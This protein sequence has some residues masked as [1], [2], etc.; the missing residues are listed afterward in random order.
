[1]A[2]DK[3]DDTNQNVAPSTQKGKEPL[4]NSES[5]SKR[6]SFDS[7]SEMRAK[8]A[9]MMQNMALLEQA[10]LLKGNRK[11][12]MEEHRFWNTQPVP[13]HDEEVKD[14]GCIEPSVPVDQ[15]SKEA[16]KLP[17]E[18][19][20][21]ELDLNDEKEVKELYELLT[22]NYVEDDDA[23]FRFDYSARFLKW[24][25]QPP[26]WKKSWHVGVRV[27]ANKKL[28]A[29]ISGIPADL[30]TYHVTQPLTE[31]NFLC[32]H[33]K[34]RSKRLAPVL[35]REITRRSHLENIFQAVYTAGVV[36]PKP[37]ATCRYFHR[38]LN[39]KKLV[40]CNFSH[41]P[42]KWTLA[43]MIKH[44]KVP[45]E[46]STKGLR[47]MREEDAE[48]VRVLL[49]NYL[50]R[51]D[52]SV[53]FETVE[54]VKH[55]IVP[56]EDV[57]WSYVVE[58]TETGK[59]TDMFSFYS[60]PS[61]VINNPKHSTLNAAYMFYYAIDIPENHKASKEDEEK[62]IKDRLNEL[63]KDALV[64]AR[65]AGFDV[66]NALKLM[67]NECFVTEQ[68]FGPG[69]GYLNYYLY[70]WRCPDVED[71]NGFP[72]ALTF[73]PSSF[74]FSMF[75]KMS[76]TLVQSKSIAAASLLVP[77]PKRW[78]LY[79]WPFAS[80]FYPVFLYVYFFQYDVYLGSEEWTFVSLGS[81]LTLHALTF[82]SCQ[83]SVSIKALFTCIKESDV[84][85]ATVI[86]LVPF[87]YQGTGA[88]VEIHHGKPTASNPEGEISFIFQ[89]KK[90]IWDSN[91]KQFRELVYPSDL[92]PPVATYQTT[93]GLTTEKEINEVSEKYGL[94]R[95]EIP[96]PTF[97]ELF[98][99][100]AV[101]PF[102]VFQIF[103]V[104][105]W[106][107]DEYWY[108]SLF[109]LFMLVV[110]E[111]TVVFQRLKTI[112]EF[113]GMNQKP[114]ELYVK[115]QKKWIQIQSD[116]LLPGDLVSI[117][118]TKDDQCVPCD[119]V[120]AQGSCIV[121]EAMLSGESTP[122]LKESVAL[123]KAEEEFD[124]K[125]ADR[126]HVLYGGTKV[127]QVTGP[128]SDSAPDNGCL[129]V[130]A[131]T[132]F[133]TS[134][135]ELVRT[136]IFSTERVS[137][138]NLEA[139]L[140]ILFLLVF[141]IAASAYVWIE[142]VEKDRKRSK[143]LLD[144]I[145][146]ITSV[147][148]PELPMELSLAVNSSLVALSKFAIFCTEPFR[149]PYAGRV[150]VCCFDKTGTLTGEDLKLEGVAFA[151]PDVPPTTL[152]EATEVPESTKWVLSTAHALVQLED[153]IIGDPMEKETLK[154]LG[155]NLGAHD[156]VTPK[157]SRKESI[158]I[159]R[160]FQ[161]S[162]ALKR[163]SSVSILVHP[164]F[165]QKKTLVAV[166]GAPETLR[167]MY[168]TVPEEYD[169]VY[170]HFTR[171]GSRVLALGY[172][173][174]ED[175]MK[176]EQI[177][178]ISRES[179]ESDLIFAGFIVFTCP[180]KEDAVEA[181][182][183]LNDSSHRCVMITGDNPLTACAVAREVG[184]VERD[185]LIVDKE[186]TSKDNFVVFHNID[187]TFRLEVDPAK[188]VDQQ[189]LD[190]H[191]ICLTGSAMIH[192][193]DNH[194]MK[195]LLEHTWV[196]ARVSPSQKEYLLT[197]YK[198]LGYTTL[199]AGDGTNDVGAL[200]QAHIGVAL[201]DGTPEDLQ[202]IA[203]RQRIE[204]LKNMYEQQKQLAAR[205]NAPLPPPP[206]A[207]AH[208]YP[209]AVQRNQQAEQNLTP[210]QKRQL[211]QKKKLENMTNKLME[212]MDME[213]PPTIKFGDASVAAPFTSKLR[214]V[215]AINNIIRQGRCTLV[216]T[217]QMYK[218]LA[219]NCLISAYSLSVLYLDGIKFGDLQVTISGMLMAVCFLC[220]SR[221]KPLQKLSKERPQPNIFNPYIILSVLGQFAVHIAALVYINAL[222]KH[223]EPPKE[224]D[225]EGEFEPSLLNSGVYLI[226]LAM[227]VSTFAINYQ[228]HPFRERIQ[229][230]KTLY[231][232][233]M[234]V[235]GIALAGATEMFPEVNEQLKLVKFP[236]AFR[237]KLT[238]CMV[239]DFGVSYLIEVVTK[240]LFADN[241]AK[242]IAQRGR[243]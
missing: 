191:D 188:P 39:P 210:A 214:N 201:L 81:I 97:T 186:E 229:D 167:T 73:S 54:D 150:D 110:F 116:E 11:K 136:M 1:M 153:G 155:W 228:G 192:F 95:F 119:L 133:G 124:L 111:G 16:P 143:L 17:K 173:F 212:D 86:K 126:L 31:I 75:A 115:R 43:R 160:R 158:H 10:E 152:V 2:N 157:E 237:D 163:Q 20:W 49:N 15:V 232:G 71:D 171:K 7:Q 29:F 61:T 193:T 5:S 98:K 27:A 147:V 32:V 44:Y 199:M 42:P 38:S 112:G 8:L 135:G 67:D 21:C 58:N 190:K 59:I 78:H 65:N 174:L 99:E 68:K 230:N 187:D 224:V 200:K 189:L 13:Q 236:G 123:R 62:Y 35:I 93:S 148:P 159:R 100:H 239:L 165:A 72:G 146:I 196:Y 223:Y 121:N 156:I 9:A 104:G 145:L 33:K 45:D 151:D 226:Q 109:T 179:V 162:S 3:D 94:N 50:S 25:L 231:Y 238:M 240:K 46:T 225:L 108:Y 227:Q 211:E 127:L 182:K 26:K 51:F 103:C 178:D 34:L 134:Q 52:L 101:A 125:N 92:H 19:E 220:I 144:C 219:L 84:H 131:R 113:R 204:R 185:V 172:K 122:L 130:V 168:I 149:I 77:L 166:K 242:P 233:L 64:L 197:G 128:T 53:V 82:L 105:L 202:K 114:F 241:R 23:Q 215:M 48:E 107:L 47:P 36:L 138:N 66:L 90:F 222:A 74:G 180:L 217:I 195:A 181:L 139:L 142:G 194:N 175:G 117:V 234:S 132:G 154:A 177:N 56:H 164:Q 91:K 69:D 184:I 40:E 57:V 79:V 198:D 129:C 85:K 207:I 24:A 141:A 205:F 208:L 161:F 183:E 203:E 140:F 80:M 12:T 41:I 14:V 176:A 169:D 137:A 89:Q 206:P 102:F 70:N 63:I 22:L 87:R 120:I 221:G 37:V 60:L 243:S 216:A 28:V 83:W 4:K 106:C 76:Q 235:G 55:W 170:R 118:R 88:L 18:F 213:E 96:M 209:D 218:I 6:V 30:R